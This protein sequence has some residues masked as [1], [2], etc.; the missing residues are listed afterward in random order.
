MCLH[1]LA[2]PEGRLDR[3]AGRLTFY[4]VCDGC[5]EDLATVGAQDYSPEPHLD[6][7]EATGGPPGGPGA[8]PGAGAPGA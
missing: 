4:L 3:E 5:G 7:L 1:G 8:Q 2:S 6:R